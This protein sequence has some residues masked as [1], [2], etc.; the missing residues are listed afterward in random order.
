MKESWNFSPEEHFSPQK[1]PEKSSGKK[2]INW[3]VRMF[4][5]LQAW[6]Y[7]TC[8]FPL[9]HRLRIWGIYKPGRE[10]LDQWI[11]WSSVVWICDNFESNFKIKYKF[12][13]YLKEKCNFSPE[14]HFS[15]KQFSEKSSGKKD[16]NWIVRVFCV[17]QALMNSTCLFPLGHRLRICSIHKLGKESR[18]VDHWGQCRLDLWYFW[19]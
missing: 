18:S 5:V 1:I 17:L 13:K 14:Q 12:W 4:C 9:G 2:D 7:S 10:N 11:T 15:P 16:I 3:I 6:I 8:L 19:K